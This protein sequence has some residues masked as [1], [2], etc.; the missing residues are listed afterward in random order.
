MISLTSARP[1]ALRAAAAL[2]TIALAACG[3]GPATGSPSAAPPTGMTP[4][5][6]ATATAT[7]SNAP[8]ATP[9]GTSRPAPAGVAWR[10][11]QAVPSPPYG[12]GVVIGPDGTVFVIGKGAACDV[13]V[14]AFDS[15]GRDRFG[16]PSCG[17]GGNTVDF[18]AVD[19]GGTVYVQDG[20]PGSLVGIRPDGSVGAG[21]PQDYGFLVGTREAGIVLLEPNP[22]SPSTLVAYDP[23][24]RPVP[25]W[26]VTVP[27]EIPAAGGAHVAGNGSVT[28]L[29]RDPATRRRLVTVIEP[30]GS[31]RAGWPVRV[32][33]TMDGSSLRL[34]NVTR[35]GRVV[36]SAH[37]PWPDT[38]SAA[39]QH[40]LPSQLVVIT[41]EGTIPAGW[42]ARLDR[43]LSAISEGPDGVLYAVA[44]DVVYSYRLEPPEE[45]WA[46]GPYDVIALRKD[47]SP[48]PGWPVRLPDG[49]TPQRAD[50][51]GQAAP[52]A[53]PP[54][55]GDDGRVVV[56]TGRGAEEREGV[57]L[58]G[59]G[60]SID[61]IFR[62]PNGREISRGGWSTPGTPAL[63][64]LLARGRVFLVVS[65]GIDKPDELWAFDSTGAAVPGWPLTVAGGSSMS[66]RGAPDGTLVVTTIHEDPVTFED[67][68]LLLT[69]DP[70]ATDV[71]G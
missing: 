61:A 10:W 68:I 38:F 65:P 8:T 36:L 23:E 71:G 35:D 54:I 41:P 25:G 17:T 34:E 14:Y 60:G 53:Q 50:T 70:S 46:G 19:G 48:V 29:Y 3:P 56:A 62:L 40:V 30:D 15:A 55:V 44:G 22:S 7:S 57:V 32:P 52:W 59:P 67:T 28:I 21:W 69:A 43:P 33:T 9:T 63:A 31:T 12:G 4:S 66:V 47:G 2:V 27:G 42:P 20:Y 49:M 58:L 13:A 39:A 24:G 6:T 18:V 45:A 11:Q 5:P 64:P 1:T 37:E 51:A 16:W 26:P